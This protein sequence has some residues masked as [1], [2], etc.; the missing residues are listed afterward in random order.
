MKNKQL[1]TILFVLLIW[2]PK[3][4]AQPSNEIACFDN[5]QYNNS[6]NSKMNAYLL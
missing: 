3:I 6:G 1:L 5:F 4:Q 2:I